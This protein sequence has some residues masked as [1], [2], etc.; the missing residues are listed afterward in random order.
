[1]GAREGLGIPGS[2]DLKPKP[3]QTGREE[4]VELE[5]SLGACDWG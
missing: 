5:L 3:Y 4:D 1:M 2:Y